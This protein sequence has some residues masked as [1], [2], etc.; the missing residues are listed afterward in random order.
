MT[1]KPYD[2]KKS[3]PSRMARKRSRS[4]VFIF[5][6]KAKK[7]SRKLARTQAGQDE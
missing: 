1:Y 7:L 3:A 2:N 6:R 5:N 4:T